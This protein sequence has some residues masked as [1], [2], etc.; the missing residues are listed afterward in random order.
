MP[1]LLDVHLEKIA[2]VVERGTGLAEMPLLLDRR[3]L[4]VALRNDQPAQDS[5]ML[6]RHFAPDRLALVLPKRNLA[7]RL[8]IGQKNP[9]SIVRH[10]DVSESRPALRVGRS[11]RPQI[12][13]AALISFGPHLAPP[14]QKAGLP[15]FERALQATVVGEIHVVGNPLGIVDRHHTL[16]GSNS[17]RVPVP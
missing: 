13:V 15:G 5:A 14:L 6:A 2:Q 4:G 16:L 17:G 3:G 8:E 7:I 1:S 9:P 12:Y 11:R 10:L